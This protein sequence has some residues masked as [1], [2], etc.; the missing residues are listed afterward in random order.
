MI[1]LSIDSIT[2][3]PAAIPPPPGGS[4]SAG[5]RTP[6]PQRTQAPQ[7]TT[8]SS[9]CFSCGKSQG[10]FI[11]AL[12]KKY[13]PECFRCVV[14]H[15][16]INVNKPFAFSKDAQGYK[17]PHHPGAFRNDL[18]QRAVFANKSCPP[19][20]MVLFLSSN[21]PSLI[22]KKCV[23]DTPLKPSDAALAVT[24]LNPIMNDSLTWTMAIVAFVFH[25]ADR[26]L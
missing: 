14:C 18:L 10:S 22:Q 6:A 19:M 11:A 5:G 4:L 23:R 26:W 16:L 3:I 2:G 15:E 24:D 13:H 9:V 20:K 1:P 17:H 25:V 12:D 8:S 21:T 7:S